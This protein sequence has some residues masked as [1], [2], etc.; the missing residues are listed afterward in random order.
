MI[1]QLQQF[2][3]AVPGNFHDVLMHYTAQ[4]H[5]VIGLAYKPLTNLSYVKVQRAR[6]LVQP[7]ASA[8]TEYFVPVVH[9]LAYI[10]CLT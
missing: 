7:T 10:A 3:V 2:A 1:W 9:Y 5:R 6:R 8:S 4:G